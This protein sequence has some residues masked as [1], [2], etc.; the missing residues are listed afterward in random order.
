MILCFLLGNTSACS[1]YIDLIEY[2][3]CIS[4]CKTARQLVFFLHFLFQFGLTI[5]LV[6][7]TGL[8]N[9]KI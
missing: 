5:A 3:A 8:I 6:Q 9:A 2:R 7:N 4:Q 1:I